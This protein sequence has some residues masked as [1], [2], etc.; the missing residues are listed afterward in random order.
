MAVALFSEPELKDS[1]KNDNNLC[2]VSALD[3]QAIFEVNDRNTLPNDDIESWG[4][5]CISSE[6]TPNGDI[7]TF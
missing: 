1:D 4:D 7:H 6:R 2:S 5:R 3:G